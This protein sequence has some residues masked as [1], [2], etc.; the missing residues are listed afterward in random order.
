MGANRTQSATGVEMPLAL[1][2]IMTG[3]N[4]T[5]L[6]CLSLVVIAALIGAEGLGYDILVA[7]QYAAKGQ[8]I[9]AGFAILFCAVV[10]DRLVQ[11]GI[12]R[13]KGPR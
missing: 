6:M 5:I 7:L 4:Q 1:P 3:I 2:S 9:L 8:G 11:G 13:E 12:K 10:I